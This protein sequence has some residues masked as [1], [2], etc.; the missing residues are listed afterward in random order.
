MQ[1]LTYTLQMLRHSSF[2]QDDDNMHSTSS[3]KDALELLLHEDILVVSRQGCSQHSPQNDMQGQQ[4][5]RVAQE[6]YEPLRITSNISKHFH[7][8]IAEAVCFV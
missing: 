5:G 8:G 7:I 4:E 6:C 2:W 1:L 3:R